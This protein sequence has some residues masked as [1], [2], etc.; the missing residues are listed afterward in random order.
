VFKSADDVV[1]GSPMFKKDN[2]NF[3]LGR[4]DVYIRDLSSG[5]LKFKSSSISIDGFQAKS[6]FGSTLAK[7]GDVNDDGFNDIAIAAPYDDDDSS[8]IIYIFRGHSQGLHKKP[9]QIIK[10]K[11]Y[12]LKTFGYSMSGGIDLDNNKYPDLIVGAY[13][14]DAVVFIRSRAVIKTIITMETTPKLIDFDSHSLFCD[15]NKTLICMGLTYCVQYYGKSVPSTIQMTLNLQLDIDKQHQ[16]QQLHSN[17]TFSTSSN[18]MRA[19]FA[20]A[21]NMTQLKTNYT[22]NYNE[23]KCFKQVVNIK[24]Y[25]RDKLTPIKFRL[26]LSLPSYDNDWELTPIFNS[27]EEASGT[28]QVRFLRNCGSDDIC[29]PDL[30]IRASTPSKKYIYGSRKNIDLNINIENRGDD[31]FEAQCIITLPFGVDYVK[32]ASIE[33]EMTV[34]GYQSHQNLIHNQNINSRLNNI[35]TCSQLMN[36]YNSNHNETRIICDIGNPM[37]AGSL[38][39]FTIRVA[40]ENIGLNEEMLKFNISC[41]SSNNE[42]NSTIYD[43][44]QYVYVVLEAV[45]GVTLIGKQLQEQ[46]VYETIKESEKQQQQQQQQQKLNGKEELKMNTII[47][48]IGDLSTHQPE[49]LK[50]ET[51]I[52]PEIIHEY[53]LINKGPSSSLKSELLITWQRN[54]KV[55]YKYVNQSL[56]HRRRQQKRSC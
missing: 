17:N 11:D 36:L 16:Q 10:G 3:D 37:L 2:T 27:L 4:V 1:I 56:Q 52:G 34:N 22:F 29:V 26:N 51:Q 20:Q 46:V 41:S 44:E 8:G 35:L 32:A 31:A 5:T 9:A 38:K 54:F 15:R 13:K 47:S 19:L 49:H 25:F 53:K 6:R 45:P 23:K 39:S 28:H 48:E 12:G 18:M 33:S 42:N 14:S 55:A 21:H 7:L 43:N 50:N 40:P 24:R 30:Q